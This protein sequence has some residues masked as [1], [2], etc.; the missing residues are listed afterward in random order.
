MY[1]LRTIIFLHRFDRNDLGP[2]LC[3][4]IAEIVIHNDTLDL[5]E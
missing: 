3:P 5:I 2:A 4:H 1:I